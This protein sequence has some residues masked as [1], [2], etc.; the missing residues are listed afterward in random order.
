MSRGVGSMCK[1]DSQIP[2]T[3]EQGACATPLSV[4]PVSI[5]AKPGK[6]YALRYHNIRDPQKFYLYNKGQ[7]RS[8]E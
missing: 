2:S 8:Y 7:L 4:S 1:I 5:Y 3:F 6:Y